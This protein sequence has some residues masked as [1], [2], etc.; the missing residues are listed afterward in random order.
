[1]SSVAVRT[2]A[3]MHVDLLALQSYMKAAIARAASMLGYATHLTEGTP[4]AEVQLE[5]ATTYDLGVTDPVSSTERKSRQQDFRA[6]CVGNALVEIDQSFHG[7]VVAG[8]ETLLDMRAWGVGGQPM[9]HRPRLAN[10]GAVFNEFYEIVYANG[11]A[12]LDFKRRALNSLVNAR[13]A[14]V[15]DRGIVTIA[16]SRG[17][18]A[19]TLTWPG[20]DMCITRNG[21]SDPIP[22]QKGYLV[23][24]RDVG[25]PIDSYD[26]VR[27][28]R[29]D[30]GDR[31]DFEPFEL[32]EIIFFYQDLSMSLV[33]TLSWLVEESQ[34]SGALG[35]PGTTEQSGRTQPGQTTS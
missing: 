34:S 13:N 18:S 21:V 20:V 16:R 33:R 15:H 9:S 30:V 10:T 22:P 23:Q 12:S 27:T 4:L 24:S 11:V 6:W 14:L 5:T 2:D 19:M 35:Q 29:V 8:I 17:E 26:V 7:L 3:G 1:M 25:C 31:I 32:A 28:K